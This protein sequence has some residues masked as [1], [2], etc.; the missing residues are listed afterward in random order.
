MLIA[1]LLFVLPNERPDL[2]FWRKEAHGK[3]IKKKQ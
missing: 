2:F 3:M 1:I